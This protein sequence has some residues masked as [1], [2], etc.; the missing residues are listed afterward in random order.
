[1]EVSGEYSFFKKDWINMSS[2]LR[3]FIYFRVLQNQ[4]VNQELRTL[5]FDNRCIDKVLQIEIHPKNPNFKIIT[6]IKLLN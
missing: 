3:A 2:F 4:G 1:M 6:K 5:I